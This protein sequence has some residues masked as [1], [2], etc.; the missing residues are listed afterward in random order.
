MDK[1]TK[2]I[3]VNYTQDWA[4]PQ[5]ALKEIADAA[6]ER[7]AA[8]SALLSENSW[9]RKWIAQSPPS[10]PAEPEPPEPA[11]ADSLPAE[12]TATSAAPAAPPPA[13]PSVSKPK[14]RTGSSGSQ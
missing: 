5:Q 9:L 7:D 13:A 3:T 11:P 10:A 8:Q 12:P 2:N 4:D 14:R 6:A 1:D